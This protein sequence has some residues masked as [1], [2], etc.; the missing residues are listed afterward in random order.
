MES[1][2][3]NITDNRSFG[4]RTRRHD[5]I[6]S[7][8]QEPRGHFLDASDGIGVLAVICVLDGVEAGK[9]VDED[10]GALE[11]AFAGDI[12][13]QCVVEVDYA[14]DGGGGEAR[15]IQGQQV[16][17]DD[18]HFCVFGAHLRNEC[19]VGGE[20]VA[21]GLLADEH[22]VCA[23]EHEDYVWRVLVQPYGEV[24]VLCVVGG[25]RARV[26]LVVLVDVGASTLASL[27]ADEI[28]V[29]DTSS[30]QLGLEIGAPA[31]LWI[32]LVSKKKWNF[33]G[34]KVERGCD[35]E[36]WEAY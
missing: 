5:S 25:Q 27:A 33:R 3:Q 1:A 31:S 36:R 22:V 6:G 18:L 4:S 16:G 12:G 20:D 30:P 11:V 23:D 24:A 29:G 7:R 26:A 32:W 34:D 28:E 19:V 8:I 17:E 35:F 10:N 14:L 15:G 9:V 21:D 2:S 13:L